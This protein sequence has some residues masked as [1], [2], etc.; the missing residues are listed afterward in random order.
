MQHYSNISTSLVIP[1]K[2]CYQDQIMKKWNVNVAE[3]ATQ[4]DALQ[5]RVLQ[6]LHQIIDFLRL[7]FGE[8]QVVSLYL[9]P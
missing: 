1:E 2:Y 4:N 5:H 7:E 6:T 8:I 9:P 3:D